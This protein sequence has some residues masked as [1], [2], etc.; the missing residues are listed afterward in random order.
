[1]N[2]LGNGLFECL[3]GFFI[4]LSIIKLYREKKVAGISWLHVGFF[5]AWGWWNLYFYPSVG[6][7]FSTVG[8]IGVV[9]TNSVYLAMILHYGRNVSPPLP[10][11]HGRPVVRIEDAPDDPRWRPQEETKEER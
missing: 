4:M 2:D 10:T 5:A 11:H 9:V 1:M 6:C 3:G 7:W 8:G